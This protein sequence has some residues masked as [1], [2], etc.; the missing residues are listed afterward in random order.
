MITL[1]QKLDLA[2][3]DNI[4]LEL[5]CI[6]EEE[7]DDEVSSFYGVEIEEENGIGVGSRIILVRS[8]DVI[9]HICSVLKPVKPDMPEIESQWIFI[10]CIK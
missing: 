3:K 2:I 6:A 8:G 10:R 9:P 1:S 4:N 7:N 5:K